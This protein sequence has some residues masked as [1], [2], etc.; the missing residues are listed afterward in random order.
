[1]EARELGPKWEPA[2]E[3]AEAGTE[4]YWLRSRRFGVARNDQGAWSVVDRD[5]RETHG[6]L[7][8]E[9]DEAFALAE[10]CDAIEEQAPA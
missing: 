9:L 5:G 6:D 3:L 2:P 10:R 1:M 8:W 4:R 7:I